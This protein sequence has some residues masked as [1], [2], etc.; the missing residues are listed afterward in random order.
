MQHRGFTPVIERAASPI[1]SAPVAERLEAPLLAIMFHL[2][3]GR[4]RW[5]GLPILRRLTRH[6]PSGMSR[7]FRAI[8]A[9]HHVARERDQTALMSPEGGCLRRSPERGHPM[10]DATG[11]RPWRQRSLAIRD[12]LG[13]TLKRCPGSVVPAWMRGGV[14][15]GLLLLLLVGCAMVDGRD[16]TQLERGRRDLVAAHPEWPPEILGAVASGVICAGMSPEMVRA[17]W[18]HPLRVAPNGSALTPR[19]IWHYAGRQ[20]TTD[21]RGDP[22]GRAQP[23][24]EWTVSFANSAVVGWTE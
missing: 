17:A 23:L 14:Q 24:R 6:S 21:L 7:V 12:R 10:G 22:T 8:P 9:S 4:D 2:L 19:D 1:A 15:L 3:E 11:G 16:S 5:R 18:G 20:H 13:L